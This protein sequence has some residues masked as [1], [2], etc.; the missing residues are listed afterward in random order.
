[1]RS[2]R[3]WWSASGFALMIACLAMV[4]GAAHASPRDA[5][6]AETVGAEGIQLAFDPVLP[7]SNCAAGGTVL[8]APASPGVARAAVQFEGEEALRARAPQDVWCPGYATT[9]PQVCLRVARGGMYS[10]VVTDSESIDT[11]MALVDS[12]G[13]LVCDDDSAGN[14]RPALTFWLEPGAY[15]VWIGPYS[16]GNRG[17]AELEVSPL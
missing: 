9:A 2:R 8:V 14:L 3:G 15:S 6:N 16:S 7:T 12:D 4:A 5:Q 13:T 17:R 1:M 10:L 11:V